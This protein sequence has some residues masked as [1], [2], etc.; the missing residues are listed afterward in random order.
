MKAGVMQF[1]LMKMIQS[2]GLYRTPKP[3]TMPV[4]MTSK[5][6]RSIHKLPLSIW[7]DCLV[8]HELDKLII[9]GNPTALEI[10]DAFESL[11]HEYVEAAGGH[12]AVTQLHKSARFKARESR[13]KLF[14]LLR[15]AIRIEPTQGLFE[16]FRTF[17]LYQPLEIDYTPENVERQIKSMEAYYNDDL[18]RYM[19][20]LDQMRVN[21]PEQGKP[22]HYTYEYFNQV[23]T[24][25]ET[26]FKINILE[27]I[28]VGKYCVWLNNYKAHIKHL[29]SQ[30]ND[31]R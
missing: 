4:A 12:E 13:V 31:I 1:G 21:D 9:E 17:P 19:N 25:I 20:E 28:T 11:Y 3:R 18:I 6:Y 27:T 5:L 7:K 2:I 22:T 15:D 24:A 10:M 16:L 30:K 29:E 23:E 8:A 14:E 26:A